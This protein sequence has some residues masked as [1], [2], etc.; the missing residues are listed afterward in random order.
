MSR[1]K[2]LA[3][4]ARH[5]AAEACHE[6]WATVVESSE[7]LKEIAPSSRKLWLVH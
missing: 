6:F 4:R 2:A 7:I 3:D 1:S 5:L